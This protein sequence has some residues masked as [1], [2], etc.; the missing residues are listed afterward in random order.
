MP[1][2]GRPDPIDIAVLVVGNEQAPEGTD[3]D[4]RG[5]RKQVTVAP[6]T[7][8]ATG[9]NDSG[10]PAAGVQ[11]VQGRLSVCVNV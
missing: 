4:S 1:T 6:I 2:M 8:H 5:Q 9:L 10:L 3:G 11:E 7:A